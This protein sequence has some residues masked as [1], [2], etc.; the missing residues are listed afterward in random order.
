LE[1]GKRLLSWWRDRHVHNFDYSVIQI[2]YEEEKDGK[3][4]IY[5]PFLLG[6][7]LKGA[8]TIDESK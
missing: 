8:T 6:G 3:F 5:T 2:I 7:R 1:G 4:T